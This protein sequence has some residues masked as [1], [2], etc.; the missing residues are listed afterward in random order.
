MEAYG[1][2]LV[3]FLLFIVFVVGGIG[4]IIYFLASEGSRREASEERISRMRGDSS[5]NS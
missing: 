2:Y 4:S 5:I 1:F 3:L